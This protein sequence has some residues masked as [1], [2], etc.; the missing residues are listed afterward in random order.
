MTWSDLLVV[1]YVVVVVVYQLRN[2]NL[3]SWGQRVGMML[4]LVLPV[5][6]PYLFWDAI[7]SYWSSSEDGPI[8]I[9]T[10]WW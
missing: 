5:V 2:R 9:N 10:G 6:V 1:L 4:I 8:D 3:E 7:A